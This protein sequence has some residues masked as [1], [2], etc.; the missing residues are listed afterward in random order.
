MTFARR[1][2]L[3]LL[4]IPILTL[5]L[6]PGVA[7]QEAPAPVEE[8]MPAEPEPEPGAETNGYAVRDQLTRLLFEH[9]NEVGTILGLDPT[10]LE[11]GSFVA[12]YPE[13]ERFLARHP[14]VRRNPHF[15]LASFRERGREHGG[16][17]EVFETL[18]IFACF[19]LVALALG[20]FIRTVI[21]QRRWS[22][23][24]QTQSEVHNKILDRF[25]S[26]EQLLAY[27]QTPAGARFLESAPIPLGPERREERSPAS[28]MLWPVQVGV[29][30]LAAAIGL[31]VVG[32]R[33]DGETAEGF[34]ALGAIG[35]SIGI[36]FLGSA[37]VSIYLSR[38]LG[39]W[40]G[41]ASPATAPPA[42]FDDTDA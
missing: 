10:L 11:N 21:E 12:G 20:W 40:E 29:V 8:A 13:L 24:A 37:A 30:L 36:G 4:L 33:F 42:P 15:Y 3:V 34:F 7:A 28:R 26:R 17:E 22:R 19:A 38:R 31:L 9:P 23:L 16:F 41:P 32:G 14:E 5:A 6:A 18:L 27:I 35:L 1:M 25:D 2:C 39:L